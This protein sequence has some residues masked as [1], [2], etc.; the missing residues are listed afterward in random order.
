MQK[1]NIKRAKFGSRLGFILVSAGCAIGL[2]NVWK[3]PYGMVQ[4]GGAGFTIIYLVFLVI[5]GIPLMIMEFSVGRASQAS[6][7]TG[8]R[9]LEKKGTKYHIFGYLGVAGNYLLMMFYTT[10]AGWMLYYFYKM[11]NKSLVNLSANEIEASYNTLLKS[12]LT[13][14]FWM[15][16]AVSLSFFVTF[17]GLEKGVE[18][19]SKFMMTS[20]LVLMLIMVIR[21]VTLPGAKEGLL[22]FLKPDFNKIKEIGLGNVIFQALGQAFFTLSIGMGSMMVFGSYTNKKRSLTGEALTITILDTSVA[23]MAGLIIIPACF[24]YNIHPG[25]G[26][27]LIFITLPN[28]FNSMP[29]GQLWGIMFF[30]FLSFAALSTVIA[31]FENIISFFIDLFGVSRRFSILIN[32]FLIII[33]SVPCILGFNVLSDFHPFGP[34]SNVLSLEDFIISQN[35]LPLGSL[36]FLFFSISKNGYGYD[37]FI[38]EANTGDGIK[39]P[40]KLKAYFLFVIPT[41][42]I[43]V[44]IK[45]YYDFFISEGLSG[46]SGIIISLILLIFL[47]YICFYNKSTK[48]K[49]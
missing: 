29:L 37:N 6:I 19:V 28:V 4:N 32:F 43:V 20:L 25:A 8:F 27:G 47:F 12:P 14:T 46:L 31:I 36:V 33:L 38:K 23:I 9:K 15:I 24:A 39:F 18:K 3:F 41:L 1:N 21:S 2:G 40:K 5:L 7:A 48:K 42:I 17:I 22:F 10:V 34:A 49:K 13:L 16:I 11:I 44:F 35:I 30:L 26:P 45:G